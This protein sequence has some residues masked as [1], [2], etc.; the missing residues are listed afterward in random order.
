MPVQRRKAQ[1]KL[2][3]CFVISC[4]LTS[5]IL[6]RRQLLTLLTTQEEELIYWYILLDLTG[7]PCQAGRTQGFGVDPVPAGYLKDTGGACKC[8]DCEACMLALPTLCAMMCRTACRMQPAMSKNTRICSHRSH[9]MCSAS[10]G[11]LTRLLH[12]A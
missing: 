4:L 1:R 5:E 7:L 6:Y 11:P 10:H 9:Q 3:S 2:L 12:L 8:Q